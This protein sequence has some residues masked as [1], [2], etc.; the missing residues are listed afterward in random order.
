MIDY[1][2]SAKLNGM[3]EEKL[4]LWFKNNPKSNKRIIRI[5]DR[6]NKKRE[7]TFAAYHPLC[8]K[9]THNT[10][11]V[12]KNHTKSHLKEKSPLPADQEISIPKN[13]NCGNYLGYLAEEALA[14]TFKKT[15]F[16]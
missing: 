1:I 16:L 5:C 9:C 4:R 6:C 2:E 14:K 10:S 15:K 7:I 8:R 11:E 12:R 3:S 13:K